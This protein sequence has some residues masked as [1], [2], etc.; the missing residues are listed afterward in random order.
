M[1]AVMQQWQHIAGCVHNAGD[2][3][4][5]RGAPSLQESQNLAAATRCC[6]AARAALRFM[7]CTAVVARGRGGARVAGLAG[8]AAG[9]GTPAIRSG[10]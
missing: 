8:V 2:R 1:L 9:A 3:G 7:Y 6:S 4:G 5:C 10:V